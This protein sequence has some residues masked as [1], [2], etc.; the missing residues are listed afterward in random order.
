MVTT[1]LR[2]LVV[3][4]VENIVAKHPADTFL[5]ADVMVGLRADLGPDAPQRLRL[6]ILEI[7]IGLPGIETVGVECWRAINPVA[8]VDA[9]P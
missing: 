7:L 4:V 5:L 8:P 6:D 3:S 1:S 2:L 9:A